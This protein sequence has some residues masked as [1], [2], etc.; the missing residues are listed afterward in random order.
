MFPEPQDKEQYFIELRL[1][2]NRNST[3]RKY[4]FPKFGFYSDREELIR[5]ILQNHGNRAVYIG[6]NPRIADVRHIVAPNQL[7]DGKAGRKEHVTAKR[8]LLIDIDSDRMADT[9]AT[10]DELQE[11]YRVFLRIREDLINRGI[12]PICGMSGNGWHLFVRTI[13]YDLDD[14]RHKILLQVLASKYD[15]GIVHVDRSVHDAPRIVKMYGTSSIKGSNTDERPWRTSKLIGVAEDLR[16]LTRIPKIVPEPVD[17]FK[18][19][20]AEIEAHSIDEAA[21]K[22]PEKKDRGA[23]P[24]SEQWVKAYT[25]N[26]STLD[27]TSLANHSNLLGREIEPGKWTVE[28]PWQAEHSMG[29]PGDGSTVIWE[30][31]GNGGWPN[32]YCS[33]SHCQDRGLREFLQF[34]GPDIVDMY[35]KEKFERKTEPKDKSPDAGQDDSSVEQPVTSPDAPS[36]KDS[37]GNDGIAYDKFHRRIINL[38]STVRAID[39]LFDALSGEDQI[40]E[41]NGAIVRISED[42]ELHVFNEESFATYI[43]R[44]FCIRVMKR[45]KPANKWVEELPTKQLMRFVLNDQDQIFKLRHLEGVRRI[46][47]YNS[48]W[49]FVCERRYYDDEGV[50]YAGPHVTP[51]TFEPGR[52]AVPT[53][54]RAISEFPFKAE[55][56]KVRYIAMAISQVFLNLFPGSHPMLLVDGNG[57]HIGK[58]KLCQLVSV[59]R[60]D[61]I[62]SVKADKRNETE[63]RI[64]SAVRGGATCLMLD[65]MINTHLSVYELLSEI[66]TMPIVKLRILGQSELLE[67]TN[68]IQF[69]FSSNGDTYVTD[70]TTRSVIV[71]LYREGLEIPDFNIEDPVE[72]VRENRVE[73]IAEMA[74]L[75]E[76]WKRKGQPMINGIQSR[77]GKWAKIVGGILDRAG[78][79]GFEPHAET[80]FLDA[81]EDEIYKLRAVI[82]LDREYTASELVDR[83]KET[84]VFS[85]SIRG[86]SERSASV[87]LA[88]LLSRYIG[89]TFEGARFLIRR[90]KGR[91]SQY[92]FES[93]NG[94]GLYANPDFTNPDIDIIE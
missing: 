44:R 45:G 57:Q 85:W 94:P 38:D 89:E 67:T 91:A 39:E 2:G 43:C 48:L 1:V 18:I 66:I 75:I 41:Y 17:I 7:H 68:D 4:K 50:Y 74:G 40:Y 84:D 33:H 63:K 71:N 10:N 77:F 86:K 83:C 20:S 93:E 90:H 51:K 79:Q 56:D 92:I 53:L 29:A 12:R 16:P 31:D 9:A 49:E 60:D 23:L 27:I 54:I 88:K 61:S 37:V 25:G 72:Y 59:L 46:P 22:V 30:A 64:V 82:D 55:E 24:D 73:I 78:I 14:E 81:T 70:I 42:G 21:R 76:Y 65:N 35:C 52:P 62:T 11:S 58:S 80:E 32:F 36:D 8:W 87:S 5:A 28:C 15:K 34:F 47:Y 19:F 6:L 3:N 13:D 69:T 26:F